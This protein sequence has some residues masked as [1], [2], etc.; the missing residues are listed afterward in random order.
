MF[1]N[2]QLLM[3]IMICA[4]FFLASCSKE[5]KVPGVEKSATKEVM[6]EVKEKATAVTENVTEKVSEVT[7]KVSEKVSEGVSKVESTVKDIT[8][9][10]KEKITGDSEETPKIKE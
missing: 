2:I 1:K 9:T 10:V 3:T 5:E 6:T 4:M 7:E 8:N